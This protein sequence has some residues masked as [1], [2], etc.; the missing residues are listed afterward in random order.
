M[1]DQALQAVADATRRSILQRLAH[2][3]ATVGQLAAL[4]P[5]SRP[6]VSQHLRVLREAELVRTSGPGRLSAYELTPAP[7]LEIEHWA[8][9]L[10]ASW[11]NGPLPREESPP[12][13]SSGIDPLGDRASA[14][15]EFR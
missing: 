11:A 13:E 14:T 3:Q 6:A 7:L 9:T 8:S 1:L 5:I 2:G 4:F 15:E 10:A 12:S